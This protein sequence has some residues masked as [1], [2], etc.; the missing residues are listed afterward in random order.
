MNVFYRVF[1][2][3]HLT[4]TFMLVIAQVKSCTVCICKLSADTPYYSSYLYGVAQCYRAKTRRIFAC[5]SIC[6]R[7]IDTHTSSLNV[8]IHTSAHTLICEH[9]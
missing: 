5:N 6:E 2:I 1:E 9:I 8:L 7:R 4:S 3:M